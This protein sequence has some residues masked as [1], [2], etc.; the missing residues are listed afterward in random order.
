MLKN[1][2]TP[3]LLLC[4]LGFFATAQS[5]SPVVVTPGKA[6]ST[7]MAAQHS[8]TLTQVLSGESDPMR[9]PQSKVSDSNSLRDCE[10]DEEED[11]LVEEIKEEMEELRQEEMA[12]MQDV[13]NPFEATSSAVSAITPILASSFNATQVGSGNPP[14]NTMVISNGGYVITCVN[15]RVAVYNTAGTNLG[16]W[17]LYDFFNYPGSG[18]VNDF[19]DPN[20]I[21]DPGADR[22]IFTCCVGRSAA[23][24]KICV[25]FSKTNNPSGGWWVYFFSGNPLNNNSWLDYP[26]IGVSTD[27]VFITGNLYNPNFNQSVIFQI[28]KYSG[29]SGA[30]INYWYWYNIAGSP[31]AVTPISSGTNSNYGPYF[32]LVAHNTG[33]GSA[34][35]LYKVTNTYASGAATLTYNSISTAA[36]QIGSNAYQSGTSQRLDVGDGRAIS[37]FMANGLIQYVFHSSVSGSSYNRIHYHRLNPS[38][39]SVSSFN[40]YST[41]Y[42]LCYPSVAW[43]GAS[44]STT[45]KGVIISFQYSNGSNFPGVGAL[46]CDNAFGISSWIYCG[47]GTGNVTLGS[48]TPGVSRWGDYT[49]ICRKRNSSPVRVW[50]GASYGNTSH[51]WTAKIFQ[52]G[53]SNFGPDGLIDRDETVEV[54]EPIKAELYPNPV[55]NGYFNVLLSNATPGKVS[56]SIYDVAGKLQHNEIFEGAYDPENNRISVKTDELPDGMYFVQVNAD[57]KLVSNEKLVILR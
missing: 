3:T 37:G 5:V 55:S 1:Q 9:A 15:S 43:A 53:L 19:F 44:T 4:L 31:F 26:R 36:W 13:P 24:S 29:Y 14:D 33:S 10:G 45:D 54:T 50:G 7:E 48:N 57:N 17:N 40:I 32:Y 22:F 42:D 6:V 52:L 51:Q 27:E 16:Q 18:V 34:T 2:L 21:Y 20:V 46:N 23:N 56:V 11:P 25:A 38:T 28:P 49:G 35:K 30:Y 41:G 8:A 12:S 47:A 39:L